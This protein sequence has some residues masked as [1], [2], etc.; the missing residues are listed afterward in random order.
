MQGIKKNR[1]ET[2]RGAPYGD[3]TRVR[4]CR[5]GGGAAVR[6]GAGSECRVSLVRGLRGGS[7]GGCPGRSGI[8][9]TEVDC[10]RFL[11]CKF[12]SKYRSLI[13]KF[14]NPKSC[15]EDL[16]MEDL[17]MEDIFGATKESKSSLN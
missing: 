8:F 6:V 12:W 5:T 1:R 9:G 4:V 13:S 14:Q 10:F 3:T 7:C 17:L 11:F 15:E 16:F 2:V